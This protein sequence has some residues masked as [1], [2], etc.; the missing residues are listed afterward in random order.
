MI[1]T[2]ARNE[3]NSMFL[4]GVIEKKNMNS[5]RSMG[6]SQYRTIPSRRNTMGAR[7][8]DASDRE[9]M[10]GASFGGYRKAWLSATGMAARLA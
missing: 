7:V 2:M 4:K 3:T 8:I 10:D 6:T 1:D 9:R 5:A